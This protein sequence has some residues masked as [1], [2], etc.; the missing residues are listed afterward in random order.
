MSD[1]SRIRFGFKGKNQLPWFMIWREYWVDGDVVFAR[2][3]FKL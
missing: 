3:L 2:V 1:G